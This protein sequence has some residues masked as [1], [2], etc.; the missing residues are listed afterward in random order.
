MCRPSSGMPGSFWPLSGSCGMDSSVWDLLRICRASPDV[1]RQS[2]NCL[3][4]Q[5]E[6]TFLCLYRPSCKASTK[7][8]NEAW[9]SSENT[10]RHESSP[11][12]R[13]VSHLA[14]A[15][16]VL[17]F[18]YGKGKKHP[19]RVGGVFADNR[20]QCWLCVRGNVRSFSAFPDA[21][22]LMVLWK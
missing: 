15:F 21:Q 17:W 7:S 11:R 14:H 22:V 13:H 10:S 4:M 1:S 8:F 3:L 9:R 20:F 5:I 18:R 16:F 6:N 12:V 2:W 19:L